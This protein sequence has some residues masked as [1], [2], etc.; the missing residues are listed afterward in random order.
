MK[1]ILFCNFRQ[2]PLKEVNET[3]PDDDGKISVIIPE[4]V[5]DNPEANESE[6]SG[7]QFKYVLKQHLN[8]YYFFRSETY[9]IF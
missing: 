6:V 9:L 7:G 3:A 8:I 1:L 4:Q 5:T 2:Q